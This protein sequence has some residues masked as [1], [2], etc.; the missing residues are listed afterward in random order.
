MHDYLR[1][2]GFSNLKNNKDVRDVI[3]L[4]MLRPTSEYIAPSS[5]EEA[6]FGEKV[7]EFASRMGIAVRGEYEENGNFHFGYYLPYFKGKHSTFKE[8]V[9]I[10]KQSDKDA[11]SGI[12]DNVKVGVSLIFQL[13]NMSDYLDYMEFHKGPSFFT[14]ISLSGLSI[15]GKIILPVLKTNEEV[16]R[17]KAES[18]SRDYMIAAAR[19]GDQDAIESLTLEDIDT[20]TM[21][22]KKILHEDVYS[23]VDT[24]FMPYGIESDQYLV[25][26]EIMDVKLVE[27]KLTG[28]EIYEIHLICSDLE[29][30][31][32]INKEDLLGEPAIGR[33]FKGVV[34]IQGKIN[35]ND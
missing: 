6:V 32:C 10:E 7:K 29:F 18:A 27:N 13:L 12:C 1:A 14:P 16:I 2:I 11:Y 23:L 31:T 25:I 33:R 34:W 22:S 4:V 5:D 24:M 35:L 28:E 30:D 17:K 26:G 15:S 3:N 9:T 20:Y 19:E 8:E 21:I